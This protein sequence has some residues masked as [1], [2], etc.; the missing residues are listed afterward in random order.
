ML[1]HRLLFPF[2]TRSYRRLAIALL[3]SCVCISPRAEAYSVLTHEAIIDILWNDSIKGLIQQRFPGTT[4]EQMQEAHAYA[5]GGAVVQDLGYY[6]FGSAYFSDLVHY[7]R[8]GD[9]VSNLIADA[10]DANEYGF[11]IGAL[12]HYSSDVMGHPAVNRSVAIEYPKLGRKFGPVITYEQDKSAH[13]NTEFGFDVLQVSK[14]RFNFDQYHSF[15][16]FKVSKDLLERAFQ[17]TY[18][19]KLDSVLTREDL[20]IGTYRWSVSK[21]IPEM[22]KVA[23]ATRNKE[24]LHIN[25]HDTKAR[26]QFLYHV[27]RADYEHEYGRTYV[28]PGLGARIMAVFFHVLPKVGPL[29]GFKYKDPTP[30]TEDL[31]FKSVDATVNLYRSE[32]N[33]LRTAKGRT[34]VLPNRDFDTGKPTAPGEYRLTDETHARL[35]LALE[36]NGLLQAPAPVREYMLQYFHQA[37]AKK[38]ERESKRFRQ[39]ETEINSFVATVPA[40]GR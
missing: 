27:S 25:E 9:F 20:A 13:L 30:Q 8:T 23:L 24:E 22:T 1:K 36:K 2:R 15:V 6:P 39:A 12:A 37:K 14:Q 28:K 7:V 11:A 18:G 33:D 40:S 32:L 29:K 26:K 4:P 35:A 3:L 10:Q 31:Y 34:I 38:L 21:V 17:E 16:G 5:Y 19:V